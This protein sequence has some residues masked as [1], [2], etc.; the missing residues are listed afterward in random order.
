M[1]SKD[2]VQSA[3]GS[4]VG[5]QRRHSQGRM[6]RHR[7]THTHTHATDTQTCSWSVLGRRASRDTW[8]TPNRPNTHQA[9]AAACWGQ[10]QCD[11]ISRLAPGQH[12][13]LGP[14]RSTLCFMFQSGPFVLG[15]CSVLFCSGPARP[16]LLFVHVHSVLFFCFTLFF[17]TY[18]SKNIQTLLSL[19]FALHADL[20]LT[21]PFQYRLMVIYHNIS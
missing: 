14:A 15:A 8:K 3:A 20:A 7:D 19:P 1:L 4:G 2:Q 10:I 12:L 18:S 13:L 5:S 17:I 16:T 9:A 6:V 11:H 21:N